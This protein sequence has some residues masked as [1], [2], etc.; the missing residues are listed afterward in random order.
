MPMRERYEQ[1]S[2]NSPFFSRPNSCW[3]KI[4]PKAIDINK[5]L[6]WFDRCQ[7]LGKMGKANEGKIYFWGGNKRP[8]RFGKSPRKI[9]VIKS[10]EFTK[11][12]RDEKLGAA[13][14]IK[15]PLIFTDNFLDATI[16]YFVNRDRQC[17]ALI[18]IS[19]SIH[20]DTISLF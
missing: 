10:F 5:I 6:C 4:M 7:V 17:T 12:G 3:R 19:N 8:L 14:S 11:N 9:G 15:A 1:S 2:E 16:I 18:S 13:L 20:G